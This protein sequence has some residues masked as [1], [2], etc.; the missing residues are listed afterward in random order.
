MHMNPRERMLAALDFQPVDVV[1]L[2]IH[3]SPA[4]LFEHGQKLLELMRACGH[5]FGDLGDLRLPSIPATDFDSEG[6]YHVIRTDE[7]GTTWEH[8][9]FGVWG[10]RTGYPLADISRLAEYKMPAVE[11]LSG[12]RLAAQQCCGRGSPAPPLLPPGRGRKPVRNHAIAAPVR[13]RFDRHRPG[14]ARD[15]PPGGQAGG[16]QPAPG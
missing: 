2:Q 14:H 15:Q 8:R 4:G 12:V 7:W 6:R 1:P 3:P 10:Y 11:R 16:V 5:D 13:G 9:I